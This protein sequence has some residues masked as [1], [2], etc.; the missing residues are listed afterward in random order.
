MQ[1]L[2]LK[3]Y[4]TYSFIRRVREGD[5]YLDYD[6]HFDYNKKKARVYEKESKGPKKIQWI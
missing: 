3:N 4:V 2:F 1:V 6:Y 5:F